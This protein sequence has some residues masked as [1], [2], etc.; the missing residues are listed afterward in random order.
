MQK[1]VSQMELNAPQICQKFAS[2][3]AMFSKG[4]F[5]LFPYEIWE[6]ILTKSNITLLA[7]AGNQQILKASTTMK[8]VF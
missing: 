8:I 4:F 3:C 7:N 2:N 5:S 1:N 6:N